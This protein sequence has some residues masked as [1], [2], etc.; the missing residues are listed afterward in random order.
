MSFAE[1]IGENSPFSPFAEYDVTKRV[2]FRIA[3]PTSDGKMHQFELTQGFGCYDWTN[4][5]VYA[6]L[7]E[8]LYWEIYNLPKE[9]V[10]HE[11]LY[12]LPTLCILDPQNHR[13]KISIKTT[14]EGVPMF[15]IQKEKTNGKSAFFDDR[16]TIL[17][18]N[19]L[20]YK[21]DNGWRA[22]ELLLEP[23]Q[24]VLRI[25]RYD[26]Q[27]GVYFDTKTLVLTNWD[28]V[29]VS[30]KV[31]LDA[32]F[33]TN[34]VST[35]QIQVID[36]EGTKSWLKLLPTGFF[37]IK[38]IEQNSDWE[39]TDE[40]VCLGPNRNAFIIRCIPEKVSLQYFKFNPFDELLQ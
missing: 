24:W 9:Q 6:Y 3:E 13:C 10:M 19:L 28:D 2:L 21:H 35:P 16:E 22:C 31:T 30:Y 26:T 25:R 34:G 36:Y 33:E 27:P 11:M 17:P 15:Y 23:R 4:T 39:F 14:T 7:S 5:K 40:V 12:S 1:P 18:T 32:E 29:N 38:S 37:A 8:A 20:Y